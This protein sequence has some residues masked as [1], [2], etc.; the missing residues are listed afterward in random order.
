MFWLYLGLCTHIHPPF[1]LLPPHL[2]LLLLCFSTHFCFL[3]S[4]RAGVQAPGPEKH[5]GLL[6]AGDS[7][8]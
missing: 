3:L 8:T 7:E 6:L 5:P 1:P 2:L 4:R